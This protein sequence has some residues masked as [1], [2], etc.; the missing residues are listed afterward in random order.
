MSALRDGTARLAGRTEQQISTLFDRYTNGS[1]SRD[2]FVSLAAQ[3]LA[4]S[5]ARGVAL[6]DLSLTAAAVRALRRP[7][8]PIGITQPEGDLERL[9]SSVASVLDA[10]VDYPDDERELRGSQRLRLGRLA[11]DSTAEV[12]PWAMAMLMGHRSVSGWVRETDADPC[13][14][15]SNLADGIVRSHSV[16]MKRH[17]GCMCVPRAIFT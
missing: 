3:I 5:R 4:T 13:K 8:V 14:V 2:A 16:V 7:E 17:T 11:R 9:E 10:D 1:I 15:C 12:V 6:A